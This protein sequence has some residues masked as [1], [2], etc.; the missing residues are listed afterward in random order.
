MINMQFIIRLRLQIKTIWTF[1]LFKFNRS[2]WGNFLIIWIA[3]DQALD[4]KAFQA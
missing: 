3:D 2:Q 1:N 4:Q